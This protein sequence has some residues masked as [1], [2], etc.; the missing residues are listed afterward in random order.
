MVTTNTQLAILPTF[1]NDPKEDKTSATEW[2]QK[3]MN[4]KQG[5]GCTGLLTD[6]FQKCP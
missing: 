5:G 4:N 6:P 1:S 2:L 3:L